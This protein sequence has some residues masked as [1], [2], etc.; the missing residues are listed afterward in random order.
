MSVNCSLRGHSWRG[1]KYT[2]RDTESRENGD[3]VIEKVFQECARCNDTKV[4]KQQTKATTKTMDK[5]DNK[6]AADGGVEPNSSDEGVVIMDD[7]S[8]SNSTS[9]TQD[10]S[11]EQ[12]ERK[13]EMRHSTH[14]A[15]DVG[16]V[17]PEGS[18]QE[19]N[20]QQNNKG[21][22][23]SIVP[24]SEEH[25][26]QIINPKTDKEPEKERETSETDVKTREE[27]DWAQDQP[28]NDEDVDT[29]DCP[30]C[31]Y[32]AVTE[33]VAVFPGDA[34]PECRR[35]YLEDGN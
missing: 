27:K 9:E 25:N 11:H 13:N 12:K 5:Q 21:H 14:E 17:G 10:V 4:L 7:N 20:T 24:E 18:P 22:S 31:E 34:C 1:D 33:R 29:V 30:E 16:D 6:I 3:I 23:A 26:V 2:E 8:S 15:H 35:G 19:T 28:E 32:T